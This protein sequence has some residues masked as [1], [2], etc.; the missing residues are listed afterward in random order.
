MYPEEK[1]A[2]ML[3]K[4]NPVQKNIINSRDEGVSGRVVFLFA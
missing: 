2:D 1:A 3:T 4:F